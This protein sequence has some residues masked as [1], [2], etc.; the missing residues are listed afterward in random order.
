MRRASLFA[1]GLAVVPLG[2]LAAARTG[3]TA[4]RKETPLADGQGFVGSWRMTIF[5]AEG[6]PTLGLATFGA[7]RT[8]VTAEHPVV[9]PPIAPG[10]VFTSSGH[11][12]WEPTGPDTAIVTF[13]G[14]G[15]DGQGSLFGTLTARA[16]ITLGAAGQT[17][18]GEVAWT[19][20]DPGGNPL[21]TYL[22][23]LQATRIVAEAPGSPVVSTPTG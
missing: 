5:E 8:V 11:G 7:D 1:A 16:S 2:L 19:I 4:T 14:L 21:A 13:V 18:S 15:G 3:P 20:A 22:G 12:A 17:F 6:P 9:T 10:V 23:S